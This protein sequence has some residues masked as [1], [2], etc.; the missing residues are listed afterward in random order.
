MA[1][2]Q[3]KTKPLMTLTTVISTDEAEAEPLDE[4]PIF[5]AGKKGKVKRV[6]SGGKKGN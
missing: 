2:S 4:F 5:P 3:T 1:I 6:K